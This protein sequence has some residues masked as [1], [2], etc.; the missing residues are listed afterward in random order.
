MPMPSDSIVVQ[1]Y[2]TR[3]S[4]YMV[5]VFG[6]NSSTPTAGIRSDRTDECLHLS[7]RIDSVRKPL[8]Q[9]YVNS[10]HDETLAVDP[11][12]RVDTLRNHRR[13]VVYINDSVSLQHSDD[14][15]KDLHG[16]KRRILI[17]TMSDNAAPHSGQHCTE[18]WPLANQ[19]STA[20]SCQK[21][22]FSAHVCN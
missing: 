17:S 5:T 14:N 15:L 19:D 3:V 7:I 18:T 8:H 2:A 13:K 12:G 10:R 22:A 9:T 1:T 16:L 20:S 6:A 21:A 11:R 4:K